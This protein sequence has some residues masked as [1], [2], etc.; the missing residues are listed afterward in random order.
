VHDDNILNYLDPATTKEE[1][2]QYRKIDFQVL[3][4]DY[5]DHIRT[6]ARKTVIQSVDEFKKNHKS[7]MIFLLTYVNN[8]LTD[9]D[10]DF[11]LTK[12]DLMTTILG[13][14]TTL[15]NKIALIPMFVDFGY[16][17]KIIQC[18]RT[19]IFASH[20]DKLGY[21][22][23]IIIHNLSRDKMGLEKLQKEKAFDILMEQK[24]LFSD[25][26]DERLT[27]K[28]GAALISL[29][30]ND[31]PSEENKKLIVD[32]SRKLYDHCKQAVADKVE[33]KSRRYHLSELL[34]L[35]H[36]AFWNTYVIKSILKNET[37]ETQTPIQFFSQL[38]LN[39]YGVL[40]D[41]EP[42]DLE[43]IAAE[44]LLKI[45][46]Q[47]SSYPEYRKELIEDK[48]L[49]VVIESLAE[50]EE[51]KLYDAQFIWCNLT[52]QTSLKK[53]KEEKSPMIY[54]SYDR[55]DQEFCKE[56]VKNLR[57]KIAIPIPIWVDYEH[58]E[59]SDDMWKYLTLKLKKIKSATVIMILVS[60]A[61]GDEST[62]KFRKLSHIISPNILHDETKPLIVV[63]VEANYNFNRSW[64][65]NLLRDKTMIPYEDD[66]GNMTDKVVEQIG[67]SKKS[68]N[69][70]S[71]RL[72]KDVRRK[73][74]VSGGVSA[75]FRSRFMK[76]ASAANFS[77]RPVNITAQKESLDAAAVSDTVPD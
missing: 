59:S 70:R 1:S 23:F 66:I 27:L 9:T 45:L 33:L 4:K 35:L 29:A 31:E 48:Q 73:M 5:I 58:V 71:V 15:T 34:E 38:F 51:L 21:L 10:K 43:K 67:V 53:P 77:V 37:N 40:L 19:N 28:F 52:S 7:F 50:R 36:R 56:F 18:V 20:I 11:S 64:M 24:Q 42:D 55:A 75:N 68:P 63:N 60:T 65:I 74:V 39:F 17:E 2:S 6:F 14:L 62:D 16:A 32:T 44:H 76:F 26:K 12:L 13:F 46:L 61:C 49:C 69:K 41:Q 47:I 72:S 3:V 25:K 30:T 22:I 8:C 57:G 54:V